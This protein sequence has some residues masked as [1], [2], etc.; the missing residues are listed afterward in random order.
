MVDRSPKWWYSRSPQKRKGF[1]I[2]MVLWLIAT[3]SIVVSAITLDSNISFTIAIILAWSVI[4]VGF[5]LQYRIST[6]K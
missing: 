5:Y 6:K 2:F 1:T 4:M 3:T